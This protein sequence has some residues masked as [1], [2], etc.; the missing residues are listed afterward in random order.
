VIVF[1]TAISSPA[2][3]EQVARPGIE[4]AAEDDSRILTRVG[5]DSVRQP[6]NEMMDEAMSEPRLEALVLLHQDLELLDASLPGRVR[7][8]LAEAGV[9]LVG[10]LGARTSRP[11]AWLCPERAFGT[12]DPRARPPAQGREQVDILDG[13]LLVLAP[14]VVRALRFGRVGEEPF[15]GYDVDISLRVRACGGSVI[16]CDLPSVHRRERKDDYDGQR[17]AGIALARAWDPALRP[18]AWQGA[19]QL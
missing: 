6:Y 13:A 17:E 9:G 7:G 4:R 3:Y 8:A 19:F 16:C 5:Y 18:A 14:W 10:P 2:V 15:H 1:G 11:H 12:M